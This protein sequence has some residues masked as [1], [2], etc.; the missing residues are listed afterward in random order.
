M[1]VV[2]NSSPLIGLVKGGR[3]QLLRR[4]YA[5]VLIPTQVYREVA[6][7][8]R[9]RAGSRAAQAARRGGWLKVV[10]VRDSRLIPARLQGTGEGEAIALAMESHAE[11]LIVDDRAARNECDRQ[12]VP[13]ITTVGIIRD[14]KLRRVVRKAKPILDRMIARGFGIADY[15]AIVQAL[16]E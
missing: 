2:S 4:L 1:I 11:F 13:W 14:A 12:G 5:E 15:E 3:F 16:G 6:A 8:G 10:A 9:G 7:G